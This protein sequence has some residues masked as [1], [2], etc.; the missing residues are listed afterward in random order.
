MSR[1][2]D[3]WN[4]SGWKQAA[5]DHVEEAKKAPKPAAK[6]KKASGAD[7][8]DGKKRPTQADILITLSSGAALFHSPDG[9]AFADITIEDRRETHRVR[10][11]GFRQWLRHQYFKKTKG[12]VNSDAMQV[13]VETIAA[14]AVFE[15][16]EHEVHVR[17]AEHAGDIYIDIGDASWRVVKVAKTGWEV[18]AKPAVRF[19]R[20]PGTRAL[21]IP[22]RGGSIELL[23]PFCNVA[24][25]DD[26]VLLVAFA[27]S[28]LRPN[29]NYA[30]LVVTGEQGSCKSSTVRFVASLTDP[31]VPEQRSLPRDEDDLIT[32][33][34]GAHLL[35]FDNV[36]GLKDWLSDAFCRLATGGGTG[37]RKLYTDHD[38]VLFAGRRPICLNGIEDV[39]SRADLIDRCELLTH[40]P[41]PE[42][43]RRD[44]KELEKAFQAAAPKIMGALLDGLVA[45]LRNLSS[46]TIS[47]K[48]RMA[49][50][51]LWA[52]ACTRAY[53][54]EG[55]FLE[56]YRANLAAS[57]DLVLESSPVG[58]AVRL[59]MAKRIGWEGTASELLPLL[60]AM[61]G[62][63]VSKEKDWP[64]Y[65]NVLSGKLRRAAPALRK[66]GI[67]IAFDRDGH[68]AIRTITIEA[69]TTEPGH[70]G[71]SSSASSASSAAE[72]KPSRANGL[73]ADDADGMQTMADDAPTA[74]RRPADDAIVGANPLKGNEADGADDADGV[75]PYRLGAIRSDI[76]SIL[77]ELAAR[78]DGPW[79]PFGGGWHLASE[80]SEYPRAPGA[81]VWIKEVVPP[82]LS[83]GPDDDL[84]DIDPGWRQ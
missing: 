55:T 7:G 5:R 47:D 67:H 41:I 46:V 70:T 28:V 75:S 3:A 69:R 49:D 58:E 35:P 22:Q 53:W 11:Q 19:Q 10:G 48:P 18:V 78:G 61:V 31:R 4:D 32:A 60:T 51:A 33:A 38:E 44:E 15:G 56:A 16:P 36:S 26:F 59:F 45:G 40:E 77:E 84:L 24:T 29:S 39:V 13:A 43:K 79:P 76:E 8:A 83:A 14:K 1:G 57:V 23:R 74:C 80:E 12:G 72:Q 64:K 63:R 81:H 54:K 42:K 21:P 27:L 20:S 50:F 25:D 2:D 30:I 62:E 71:K 9:E 68:A 73:G 34:K 82:Q 6:G 17:I 65:A 66:T 37:K 52:E